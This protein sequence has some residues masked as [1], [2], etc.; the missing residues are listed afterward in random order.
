MS[1]IESIKSYTP[2]AVKSQS[3]TSRNPD[4]VIRNRENFITQAKKQIAD[5]DKPATKN[6]WIKNVD[7]ITRVSIRIGTAAI[8]LGPGT[9]FAVKDKAAAVEFI[10]NAIV[11]AGAGELDQYFAASKPVRKGAK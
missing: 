2:V 4:P 9:H 10:E 8:N 3:T 7:D 1:F 5:A 6:S 11:A